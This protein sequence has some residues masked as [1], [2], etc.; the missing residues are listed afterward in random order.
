MVSGAQLVE[1]LGISRAAVWSRI[2]ELRA[3]DYDI[4]L[5]RHFGYRLV[6]SPDALHADDSPARLGK[7]KVIG[8]PL[9]GS[10]FYFDERRD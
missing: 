8:R 9:L 2:E 5:V 10:W 7:T 6:R 4:E 3:T 1:K